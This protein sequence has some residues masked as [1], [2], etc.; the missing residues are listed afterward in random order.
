MGILGAGEGR[1]YTVV[2]DTVNVA[3][4][5]AGGGAGRRRRGRRGDPAPPARRPGARASGALTLRGK[6]E[7]VDAYVLEA[8]R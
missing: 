4:R 7:P 8:L 3:S 6:R 5:A 1:S 2:G